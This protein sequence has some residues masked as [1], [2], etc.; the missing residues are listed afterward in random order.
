MSSLTTLPNGRVEKEEAGQW[1]AR[2]DRGL[3]PGEHRELRQWLRDPRRRQ[4]LF[5]L[6]QDWDSMS[7]VEE[8]GELFPLRTE[9]GFPWRFAARAAAVVVLA[10]AASLLFFGRPRQV[11]V[12]S[13][14]APAQ[15]VATKAATAP[16]T[17]TAQYS[18]PI[19]THL[20]VQL[21]D[22][23]EVWLNT[24]TQLQVQFS[25]SERLITMGRG[26]ALFEVAK[27]PDRVFTVRVGGYDFKAVGTAFDIRAD[28]PAGLRLTVTEGRVRV[29]RT[30]PASGTVPPEVAAP[31]AFEEATDVVVEANKAVF[32]GKRSERIDQLTADQVAATTAWQHGVIVFKATPLAQVID[33]LARYSTVRFVIADP[34]LAHLPVSGYFA[35]GDTESLAAA[36]EQNVGV[37]I[38]KQNGYL[39]L[40]TTQ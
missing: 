8:L 26:E 21:P 17:F 11:P 24:N 28:A 25:D 14:A 30:P 39:L 1:L 5:Q 6:A 19:G 7:V 36:L 23:S 13:I 29:H 12:A 20:T 10:G 4:M 35:V 40:S 3:I 32:I 27:D 34:K 37:K 22:H 2:I 38:T 18:T 9:E 31:A 15:A 16:K 33:E